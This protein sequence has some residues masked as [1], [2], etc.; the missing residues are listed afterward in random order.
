MMTCCFLLTL[1]ALQEDPVQINNEAVRLIEEGHYDLA[2]RKLVTAHNLA[3]E[4]KAI[5][6]NLAAAYAKRG[7]DA[8]R[9][10]NLRSAIEDLRTACKHASGNPGFQYTLAAFLYRAGDLIPAEK[11]IQ[12]GLKLPDH[13]SLEPRL[14]LL[15]GN[16]LYLQDRLKDAQKAFERV[17]AGDKEKAEAARMASKIKRELVIHREYQQDITANF[18]IIYGQGAWAFS[19]GDPFIA[20]LEEERSQVCSDLNHFPRKRVTVIIYEPKDFKS[21]TAVEAW[22]G[23]LF[24]RKIRIPL[25]DVNRN[26]ERLRQVIRHEYTHVLIYELAP[27]CPAW[28]NEGLAT[29][30]EY[31]RGS[32]SGM[33]RMRG[34]VA[35][36]RSPVPFEQLPD[37]FIETT[38]SEKVELYYAQSHAMIEYLIDH[39]GLGRI[40]LFLRELNRGGD[41]K[42]AFRGA[43]A[44]EFTTLERDWLADLK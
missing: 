38:D 15:E 17:K 35:K 29:T 30:E 2:V 18:K 40:R 19:A 36:G 11:A 32:A 31:G 7:T 10:G 33:K 27:G 20:I 42:A 34:L 28:I 39:Y 24:D 37:T 41:W 12:K 5:L 22:V 14:R 43:F 44:R 8:G 4:S 21:V 1:F 9:R 13:Q 6:D 23:G 26:R 16:I 3:P 25:S